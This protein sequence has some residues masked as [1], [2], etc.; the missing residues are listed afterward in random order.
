MPVVVPSGPLGNALSVVGT[1]VNVMLLR[2]SSFVD[3]L[4]LFAAGLTVAMKCSG[5]AGESRWSALLD[6]RP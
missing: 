1:P 3:A 5:A 4:V 6:E 2:L